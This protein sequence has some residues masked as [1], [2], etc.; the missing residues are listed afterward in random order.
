MLACKTIDVVTVP[1][2]AP[3]RSQPRPGPIMSSKNP[4]FLTRALYRA[5][6]RLE[7]AEHRKGTTVRVFPPV[8]RPES[9][10]SSSRRSPR[11]LAPPDCWR[12]AE[13]AAWAE[14]Q[15][16]FPKP[17]SARPDKSSHQPPRPTA[18]AIVLEGPIMT[19]AARHFEMGTRPPLSVDLRGPPQVVALR[20]E[21]KAQK[22]ARDEMQDAWKAWDGRSNTG[23]LKRAVQASRVVSAIQSLSRPTSPAVQSE[24]RP[25][26]PA[27]QSLTQALS[28]P[29]SRGVSF[30]QTM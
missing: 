2:I 18:R 6:R 11:S 24:S 4:D 19:D 7:F 23:A 1:W 10:S 8:D 9:S 13:S 12:A 27:L 26:S 3:T 29:G 20:R 15:S 21:L 14:G 22:L 17:R 16:I 28:R 5:H 30:A 25:S